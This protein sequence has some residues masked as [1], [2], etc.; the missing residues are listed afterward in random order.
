MEVMPRLLCPSWRW[1][2][3]R[4]RRLSLPTARSGQGRIVDQC[5]GCLKAAAARRPALAPPDGRFERRIVE[6]VVGR[7]DR[8]PGG[9]DLVDAVKHGLVKDDVRR[10]EL[11]FE[12]F[13]GAG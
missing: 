6:G 13:H 12:L 5:R 10:S 8:D 1:M 2:T 7:V 3:A 11:A 4:P 9:N